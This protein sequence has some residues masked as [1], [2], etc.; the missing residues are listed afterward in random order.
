M[1]KKIQELKND[2]EQRA[3]L[4]SYQLQGIESNLLGAFVSV[5]GS[6]LIAN[7]LG[8]LK[9]W[10][11]ASFILIW[12]VLF[13][14]L[15]MSYI[16]LFRKKQREVVFKATKV[17]QE[18]R[19][20]DFLS[21]LNLF[22]L[23][24]RIKNSLSLF[25]TV[26]VIFV[27]SFLSIITHKLGYIDIDDDFPIVLP[28]ITSLLFIS[29]QILSYRAISLFDRTDLEI[30]N[31]KIGCRGLMITV[32]YTICFIM[33]VLVLPV[34]SL[35]VLHPIYT[36][37]IDTLMALILVMFLQVITTLVFMN[38]FSASLARKEL[39]IALF[40][41]S[42]IL[43]RINELN[44][45]GDIGEEIYE[46]LHSDY[47]KAKRYEVVADDSLLIN[48]Y[49]LVPNFTYISSIKKHEI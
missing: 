21:R 23:T 20:L 24:T 31:E 16:P 30:K 38:Y 37:S 25:R 3:Q 14:S 9:Y 22:M 6:A 40:N 45:I 19:T 13:S 43:E 39:T 18:S 41:L 15:V 5:I 28:L 27:V 29:L 11:P 12:L 34:M 42:K 47:I 10:L 36:I 46:E 17:I 8:L 32:F 33:A 1:K 4:I 48:Y 44:T 2:I 49:S 26:G 7:A 35:V